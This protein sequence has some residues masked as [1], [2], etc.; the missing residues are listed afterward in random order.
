MPNPTSFKHS[1]RFYKSDHSLFNS[2]VDFFKPGFQSNDS[3]IIIATPAHWEILGQRFIEEGVD[4]DW[5]TASGRFFF[6]DAQETL[7][8]VMNKDV[9]DHSKFNEVM[10]GVLACAGMNNQKIRTYGE[11]VTL[12]WE[13]GNTEQALHIE[14]LWNRLGGL[15]DFSHFC[16]YPSEQA[17]MKPD[18]RPYTELCGTHSKVAYD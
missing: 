11:M 13:Q 3:I 17:G 16:G 5:E 4:I 12:L 6:L 10:G 2:V 7:N 1:V 9:L 18:L 15:R 14:K 8:L